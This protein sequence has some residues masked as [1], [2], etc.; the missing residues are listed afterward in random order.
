MCSVKKKL[1]NKNKKRDVPA[2]QVLADG[3]ALAWLRVD[4]ELVPER[5]Q[6]T[7]ID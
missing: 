4:S 5:S 3:D 2:P 6:L 1:K 7:K